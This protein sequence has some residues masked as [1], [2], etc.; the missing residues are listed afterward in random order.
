MGTS[1]GPPPGP[2]PPLNAL[3]YAIY[4]PATMVTYSVPTA[5]ICTALDPTNLTVAFNGPPSGRVLVTMNAFGY[6][7]WI[8]PIA[9]FQAHFCLYRHNLTTQQ[10]ASTQFANG[11]STG[12]GWQ[13][14]CFEGQI[15]IPVTPG[16][17]YSWDWAAGSNGGP[18]QT[19]ALYCGGYINVNGTA[20]PAGPQGGAMSLIVYAG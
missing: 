1:G 12:P 2:P 13:S 17:A 15:W 5:G 14:M 8:T 4:Q 16:A 11:T 10:G 18:N 9:A 3:A 7:T 20:F 19:M 6:W